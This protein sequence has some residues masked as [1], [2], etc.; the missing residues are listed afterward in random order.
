MQVCR[1][2][3][4][5]STTFAQKLQ[6]LHRDVHNYGQM[7]TVNEAAWGANSGKEHT[8]QFQTRNGNICPIHLESKRGDT[9]HTRSY[10]ASSSRITSL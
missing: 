5:L 7:H 6:T 9:D 3:G 8:P 1:M 2:H 10:W 4:G